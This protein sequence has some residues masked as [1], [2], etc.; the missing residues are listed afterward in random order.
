MTLPSP[1]ISVQYVT[2]TAYGYPNRGDARRIAPIALACLHVTSNPSTPP[3]TAQQERDYANRKGSG[4]PSAHVY[5]NR[6]GSAVAAVDSVSFAAWSNGD[7][8][9]P[10]TNESG[11]SD[12]LALR[13]KGFNANEAYALE[14]EHCG[15]YPDFPITDAQVS[16]SA[17]LIASASIRTGLP[18]DR[19]HVH[20]HSDLNTETRA[21]CPVPKADAEA[22]AARVIALAADYAQVLTLQAAIADA[23]AA[24]AELTAESADL[25]TKLQA[26]QLDL[27]TA[28]NQRDEAIHWGRTVQAFAA[29]ALATDAPGWAA[30]IG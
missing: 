7:V 18:I 28:T 24:I 11:I 26:A 19:A 5:V 2:N 13:A 12:V 17:F 9:T 27:L 29:Q 1:S 6:D 8:R 30:G 16:T 10:R 15:R 3:A 20:L 4:G 22:F 14:I 25:T 21:N 23:Q